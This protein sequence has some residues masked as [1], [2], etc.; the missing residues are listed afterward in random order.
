[1]SSFPARRSS[2]SSHISIF[3]KSCLAPTRTL[4]RSSTCTSYHCTRAW[5][6]NA[7]IANDKHSETRHKTLEEIAAAFG[8]RVVEVGDREVEAEG[9]VLEEKAGARHVEKMEV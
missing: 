6:G 8:D 4:F 9:N 7:T 2:W 1:M 5:V 3:R